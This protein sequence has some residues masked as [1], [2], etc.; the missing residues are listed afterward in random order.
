M[1]TDN[2][3][4]VTTALG[5]KVSKSNNVVTGSLRLS[6]KKVVN[7]HVTYLDREVLIEWIYKDQRFGISL[8][9]DY[10]NLSSWY[11]VSKDD[12][13][14]GYLPAELSMSLVLQNYRA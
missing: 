1:Y 9:M 11:F 2:N 3:E 6:A 14:S 7:P 12:M 4:L 8:D 13:D 5:I 10:P